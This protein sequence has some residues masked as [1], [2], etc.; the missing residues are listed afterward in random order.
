MSHGNHRTDH[1][2]QR[3]FPWNAIEHV[4]V[5]NR[6]TAPELPDTVPMTAGRD[7]WWHD[8]VGQASEVHTPEAF[9]AET[10]L[11]TMYTS[12]TTGKPKGLVHTSGGYLTQASW[13]Y[14]HLF[15]NPDRELRDQDVHWCTA[16]LA[17]VTAHT[18]ELYARSPTD[19]VDVFRKHDDLPGV[20]DEA[21]AAGAKTLWLQLGS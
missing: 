9:D 3:L 13:S 19:I 11:L 5:V 12:G 7:V 21:I 17:W 16:D 20:L 4:L 14:Q 15:S 2:A 1:P 6:T 8:A 18:Y 10:P